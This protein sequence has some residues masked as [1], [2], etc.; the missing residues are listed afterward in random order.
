MTLRN[1]RLKFWMLL[2]FLSTTSFLATELSVTTTNTIKLVEFPASDFRMGCPNKP[3]PPWQ[4]IHFDHSRPEHTVSLS[5]FAISKYPITESQYCQ[6]LNSAGF[7]SSYTQN[8]ELF[9]HIRRVTVF[10][11]KRAKDDFPISG[12][13][14]AGAEAFCRWLSIQTKR[15]CRLPTE[16]EWEYVARGKQN[17][18][19]PWGETNFPADQFDLYYKPI[20]VFPQLATPE[21]VHDMYGPVNQWCL[22]AYNPNFYFKSPKTNPVCING[23]DRVVRGGPGMRWGVSWL[24]EK[25]VFPP[26]WKRFRGT[27]ANRL[28]GFRIVVEPINQTT[29]S[30]VISR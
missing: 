5:A 13:T 1:D 19:Y 15:T 14:P 12:V 4:T 30:T 27:G 8:D 16:A 20:G 26:T 18:T 22:D 3:A 7:D 29:N 17:R 2:Y 11:P 6:F 25:R 24:N 28:S 21:G 10:S 23:T 9:R